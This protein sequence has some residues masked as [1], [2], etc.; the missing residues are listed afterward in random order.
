MDGPDRLVFVGRPSID[1]GMPP[2]PIA[3]TWTAPIRRVRMLLPLRL[4]VSVCGHQAFG[5]PL[6][7]EDVW[8]CACDVR[9]VPSVD[10]H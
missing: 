7:F 3:L 5:G 8:Y 6:A 9:S 4:A 1:I 2:S 10:A